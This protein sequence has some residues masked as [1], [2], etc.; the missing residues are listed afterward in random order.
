MSHPCSSPCLS[1]VFAPPPTVSRAGGHCTQSQ[2]PPPPA[3]ELSRWEVVGLPPPPSSDGAI[4]LIPAR[5]GW[6]Q[7][8]PGPLGRVMQY[9]SGAPE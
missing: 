3:R 5:A 4:F 8:W 9:W 6:G 7:G 2:H 1:Q